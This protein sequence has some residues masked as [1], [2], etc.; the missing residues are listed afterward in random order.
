MPSYV[1]KNGRHYVSYITGPTHIL[2]GL[3]FCTAAGTVNM[4]KVPPVGTAPYVPVDEASVRSAVEEALSE[5]RISGA[6]V[7]VSEVVY[8]EDDTPRYNHFK[9][10]A[11]LLAHHFASGGDFK[12]ILDDQ[13]GLP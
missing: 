9:I 13:C 12:N 2:L 3:R 11:A 6:N 5:F 10:A 4:V 8:V 7:F 1:F